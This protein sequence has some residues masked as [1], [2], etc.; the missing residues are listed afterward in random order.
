MA[1]F[2]TYVIYCANTICW[3]LF[4]FFCDPR[5]L[6]TSQAKRTVQ[7]TVL[8]HEHECWSSQVE[9]HEDLSY[10]QF[11]HTSIDPCIVYTL[12]KD[13]ISRPVMSC[14]ANVWIWS[15][16]SNYTLCS[17]CN[18][19]IAHLLSECTRR[20]V[21]R[22]R[23]LTELNN[24]NGEITKQLSVLDPFCVYLMFLGARLCPFTTAQNLHEAFLKQ[25]FNYVCK[26]LHIFIR[27]ST[28]S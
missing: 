9:Q 21:P 25:V 24:I 11:L 12:N 28:M 18:I 22:T 8:N 3:T 5:S 2:Q 26:C 27:Q 4:D 16:P 17:S 14:I 7:L 20:V 15:P 6:Q 23:L 10:F 1:L 19:E 13:S